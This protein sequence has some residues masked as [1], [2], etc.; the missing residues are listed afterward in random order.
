MIPRDYI[1]RRQKTSPRPCNP[2]LVRHCFAMNSMTGFGRADAAGEGVTWCVEL[3]SV[4]RKQLEVAAGLPRELNEL[5]QAVRNEVAI[6]CRQG[7]N[8]AYRIESLPRDF[9]QKTPRFAVARS[10]VSRAG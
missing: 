10:V 9:K 5:E 7:F 6:H 8:A 1:K 3:S 2:G 4:N